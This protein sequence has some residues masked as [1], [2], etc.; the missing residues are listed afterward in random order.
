MSHEDYRRGLQDVLERLRDQGRLDAIRRS[1]HQVK[2][3]LELAY[4]NVERTRF[5]LKHATDDFDWQAI[6]PTSAPGTTFR[7]TLAERDRVRCREH[8]RRVTG[9]AIEQLCRS[10]RGGGH[11][12]MRVVPINTRRGGNLQ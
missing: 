11:P 4:I 10:H 6:P 8:G 7:E 3:L 9:D 1:D 2:Q 5:L 12:S